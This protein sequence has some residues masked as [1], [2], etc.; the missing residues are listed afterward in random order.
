MTASVPLSIQT[1]RNRGGT[2]SEKIVSEL[3]SHT[4]TQETGTTGTPLA[5]N[6]ADDCGLKAYFSST[7]TSGTTYGHYIRLDSNGA[8]QE[9]I[10]GRFKTLL[11]KNGIGNAHGLHATLEPDT[12]A[13]AIT[14]LGTGLRANLVLPGRALAAGGTYYGLMAEIYCPASSDISPVTRHA[15]LNIGANGDATAVG[16]VLN[17]I[18]F[19]GADGTGKMIYT[20]AGTN[21]IAGTIRVLINGAA[22]YIPFFVGQ[23]A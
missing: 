12:S 13:G 10:A 4:G 21:A 23:A 22:K 17:A 19:D 2:L 9:G 1:F 7:A 20:N 5:L 16:K 14:G 11:K 18:A 8:G 6:T 15:I 3:N